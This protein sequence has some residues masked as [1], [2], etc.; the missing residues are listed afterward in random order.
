MPMPLA[1][2]MKKQIVTPPTPIWDNKI[3][4]IKDWKIYHRETYWTWE[5]VVFISNVPWWEITRIDI[6]ANW[7]W[8]FNT[9]WWWAIY[10]S[11]TYYFNYNTW[12]YYEITALAWWEE[13]KISWWWQYIT[14]VYHK[15]TSNPSIVLYNMNTLKSTTIWKWL[16]AK[17][18]HNW[19]FC[20]FL[21]WSDKELKSFLKYRISNWQVTNALNE[22]VS[23][24][25]YDFD[26]DSSSNDWWLTF[27]NSIHY[28]FNNYLTTVYNNWYKYTSSDKWY[29]FRFSPYYDTPLMTWPWRISRTEN[30]WSL[31]LKILAWWYFRES[32]YW[33]MWVIVWLYEI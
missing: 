17:V 22:Y 8:V 2:L 27:E 26:I 13:S 31:E 21:S 11:R 23:P 33:K 5:W 18:N 9:F 4:Y 1:M 20:Y 10:S 16:S 6:W 28:T 25:L 29:Y 14:T 24:Y 19:E 15:Y 3:M 32:V 30:L 7:H 12:S